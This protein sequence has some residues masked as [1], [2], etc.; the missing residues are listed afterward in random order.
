MKTDGDG[1]RSAPAY[2]LL[3]PT[4]KVLLV[5]DEPWI[6]NE[7][8]AALSDP[9]TIIREIADPRTVAKAVEE[10]EPDVVLIDLQVGSMGGMA[11]ARTLRE[12]EFLDEIPPV[13]I[14]LLLDRSADEFLAGRAAADGWVVK[15][16]TPQQLR[17]AIN[18]ANAGLARGRAE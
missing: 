8:L 3:F 18:S 6:R 4:M 2:E 11:V 5:A 1:E 12:A 9:G 7:A 13:S 14:V 15:P 10:F 16:F 17:S